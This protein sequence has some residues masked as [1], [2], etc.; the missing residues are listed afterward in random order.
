LDSVYGSALV[1]ER[2]IFHKLGNVSDKC[3]GLDREGEKVLAGARL[4][5]SI[6]PRVL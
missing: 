4:L 5:R 3:V 2:C 1:Q 6:E